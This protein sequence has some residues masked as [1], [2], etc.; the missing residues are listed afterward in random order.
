MHEERRGDRNWVEN[1]E[2]PFLLDRLHDL[3]V[4]SSVKFEWQSH[5]G[6]QGRQLESTTDCQ[7]LRVDRRQDPFTVTVDDQFPPEAAKLFAGIGFDAAKGK[8]KKERLLDTH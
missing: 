4:C 5:G 8:E 2:E 6:G 1:R 7:G 3:P